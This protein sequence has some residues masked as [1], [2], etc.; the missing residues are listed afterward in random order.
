MEHFYANLLITFIENK[1]PLVGKSLLKHMENTADVS[2]GF[3]SSFKHIANFF[4]DLIIALVIYTV[5]SL[6]S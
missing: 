6:T 1:S 2:C 5:F 3:L 4:Q